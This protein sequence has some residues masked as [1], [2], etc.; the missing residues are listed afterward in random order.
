MTI[1]P[2]VVNVDGAHVKMG[3]KANKLDLL[4]PKEISQINRSDKLNY[5]YWNDKGEFELPSPLVK[6]L[7][8]YDSSKESK[9]LSRNV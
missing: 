8:E 1:I 6:V 5:E 3:I 7:L 2:G 9:E 4:H